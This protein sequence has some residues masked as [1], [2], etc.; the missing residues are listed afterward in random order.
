MDAHT[1]PAHIEDGAIR[2]DA[3]LPPRVERIEVVAYTAAPQP[4]Q[5]LAA[6]VRSLPPG[7]KTGDEIEAE[8]REM[9]D[10]GR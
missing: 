1:I 5:S 3:P 8:M 6:F 4:K 10:W 9:R 7:D 2:L